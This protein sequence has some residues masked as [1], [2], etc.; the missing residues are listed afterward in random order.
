MVM[1]YELRTIKALHKVNGPI[2][3]RVPITNLFTKLFDNIFH[4]TPR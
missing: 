4:L 3:D 2:T 1:V